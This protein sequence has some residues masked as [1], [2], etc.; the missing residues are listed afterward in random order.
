MK[1]AIQVSALT[2]A[3]LLLTACG[4]QSTPTTGGTS[5]GAVFSHT[6]YAK[7]AASTTELVWVADTYSKDVRA[8]EVGGPSNPI[9]DITG[10][11]T[12]ITDTVHGVDLNPTNG[13]IFVANTGDIGKVH[14][15]LVFP[16]KSN[17]NVSPNRTIAAT[18]SYVHSL[19]FDP[20]GDLW[21][22]GYGFFAEYA[23]SAQVPEKVVSGSHTGLILA[24]GIAIGRLGRIYVTNFDLNQRLGRILEW[25]PPADGNVGP[26]SSVGTNTLITPNG[27][28]IYFDPSANDEMIVPD[29][30]ANEVFIWPVN[31]GPGDA[32]FSTISGSATNLSEPVGV[33]VDQAG[34]V[35]VADGD[36]GAIYEYPPTVLSNAG[37]HNVAPIWSVTGLPHPSELAIWYP[38]P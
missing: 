19:T 30:G 25:N 5:P 29:G 13:N 18:V 11:A 24:S 10:D 33:A 34:N 14:S 20:A 21:S 4:S 38:S 23:P 27:I 37:N 9:Y 31:A 2:V 36:H 8:Y 3:S 17:G 35:F 1:R 15:I 26:V 28:A 22:S 12:G 16:P 6:K 7:N 32:P